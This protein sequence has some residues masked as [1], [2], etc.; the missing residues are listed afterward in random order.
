[1][2][3]P[4]TKDIFNIGQLK[5]FDDHEFVTRF[6]DTRTKLRGFIAIHNTNAGPAVGGTIPLICGATGESL[7]AGSAA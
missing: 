5:E 3:T 4:H 1:M 6:F 7:G 2:S